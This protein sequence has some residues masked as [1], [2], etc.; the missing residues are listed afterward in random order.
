MQSKTSQGTTPSNQSPDIKIIKVSP[1]KGKTKAKPA[2]VSYL[3]VNKSGIAN[4]QHGKRTET[5]VV[6]DTLAMLNCMKQ[7]SSTYQF[8]D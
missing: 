6:G 4:K 3:K 1:V 2:K 7:N 8:Q 5:A